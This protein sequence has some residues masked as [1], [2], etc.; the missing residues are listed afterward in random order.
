MIKRINL[1]LL[2]LLSAV[3]AQASTAFHSWAERPVMGWNSWD[4]YG[5]SVDEAK[6]KAQADYMAAHLLAHGWNLITVDIQR[7]QPNP[8]GFDYN[9]NPTPVMDEWGRL[10]PAP[11]R[12]PAAADGAGLKPLADS[13]TL[14]VSRDALSLKGHNWHLSEFADGSD[15][16][17][18]ETVV[19]TTRNLGK[20]RTLTLRLVPGGGYAATLSLTH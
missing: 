2:A 11:V 20:A 19:E 16:A 5:T 4:F 6:A 3:V 12:F 18:P 7:Y 10:T 14:D 1:L 15:P 13:L 8:D 9:A 17:A